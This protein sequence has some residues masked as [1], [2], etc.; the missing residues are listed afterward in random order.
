MDGFHL[1]NAELERLGLRQSKGAPGT[2]DAVGY[3]SLIRQ[4]R[5]AE[6]A[7]VYAPQFCRE[8][9][10]PIA[11]TIPIPAD[12]PLV[13]T[14]GNYLL[15]DSGPWSQVKSLLDEA[16]YLAPDH[17]IRFDRL[18]RR[19]MAYGKPEMEARA[20][21]LGSDQRNA[22]LIAAT[23]ARADLVLSPPPIA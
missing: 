19:H 15:L 6:D 7:V 21:S 1:A 4:L 5:R 8:L 10:E 9:D 11:S 16:W 13:I 2:F 18:V 23:L 3:V 17:R 14:E 12:A 22:E 20:W